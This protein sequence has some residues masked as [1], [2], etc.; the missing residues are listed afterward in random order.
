MMAPS[1][2]TECNQTPNAIARML[3]SQRVGDNV[4]TREEKSPDRQLRSQNL[5]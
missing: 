2:G 1:R 4:H 3:R 5:Y